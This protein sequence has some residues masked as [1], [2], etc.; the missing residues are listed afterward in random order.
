MAESPFGVRLWRLLSQ[1]RPTFDTSIEQM[2]AVLARDADVSGREL[3]AVI[4]DGVVP[5]PD[6]VRK[7]APVL[8]IHTA[9]LFVIAGLPVP[10]DLASAWPMAPWDVGTVLRHVIRMTTDERRQLQALIGSL[11]TPPGTEPAPSYDDYP[12]TP[13]ALLLRL[14]RNRN[15]RA[16]TARLLKE[17]GDG[18][19]VSE[20]TIFGLGRGRVVIT[21][22][23]VT[24]FAHLL[25][26]LPSDMVALTGIGPVVEDA[27]VH[28]ASSEIAAL[29]WQARRLSTE[30]LDTVIAAAQSIRQ[31]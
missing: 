25:G 20:A 12:D 2:R 14:L 15:I 29:A 19:Y 22:Q 10:G 1:R 24:A 27:R 23:Y 17:V 28:P 3:A 21:P 5:G 26:Y 30:Q 4:R 11:P 13:A 7:L 31:T 9:D 6:L 16:S 18:P 8:G